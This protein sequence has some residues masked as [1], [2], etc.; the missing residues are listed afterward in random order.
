MKIVILIGCMLHLLNFNSTGQVKKDSIDD[1]YQILENRYQHLKD[2]FRVTHPFVPAVSSVILKYKQT[3]LNFFTSLISANRYITDA[4]SLI[5]I[6]VKQIYLYNTY[7]ITYGLSANRRF[8]IGLDLN[9]MAGRI[10]N[11]R[12]SSIFKIF[13]S[14]ISGNNK[15]AFAI[16]SIAPR[17]RWKPFK[18]NYKFTIQS[19]VSL[20]TSVSNEKQSVLGSNQI[21]F[22]SQFLYNYPLNNRLFM[23][24]Q[25]SLQYGFQRTKMSAIFYT[26][27]SI[28]LSYY[29]PKKIILFTLLNYVPVFI[30]QDKWAYSRYALQPGVGL[31][32]QVS[33]QILINAYYA[34]VIAGKNYPAIAG[35]NICMRVITL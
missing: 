29:I 9:T 28:Y 30:N 17:I 18:N 22:L 25:V 10:D 20:P 16:T 6:A 21:Y 14:S 3:E 7:Q 31:Q 35:Y 32:Y 4:G 33:K 5:D 34:R 27:V 13:N 11:D 15:Y 19:S 24:S 26:P 23:F 1:H 2:S 8:N 12:N